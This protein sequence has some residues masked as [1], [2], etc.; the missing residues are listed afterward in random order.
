[1][2]IW[3]SNRRNLWSWFTSDVFGPIKQHSVSTFRY[4]ITFINDF[5]YVWV[6]FMKEKSEAHGKFKLFRETVEKEVGWKIWCLR[7]DNGWEYTSREFFQ[8]FQYCK[9]WRRLTCPKTPQQNGVAER[10]K[11]HLAETCGSM[12]HAKNVPP[13]FWV[14]CMRIATHVTN[15]LPQARLLPHNKSLTFFGFL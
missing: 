7:T 4:M 5:I 2:K 9:I 15:R 6:D 3:S 12:L 1:M 13:L 14:E 10:K 11:C 8:Y